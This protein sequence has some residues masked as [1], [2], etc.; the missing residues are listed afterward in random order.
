[1]SISCF[2]DLRLR[3]FPAASVAA[4]SVAAESAAAGSAAAESAAAAGQP[5][6]AA[7]E[8]YAIRAPARMFRTCS[9]RENGISGPAV[10][11]GG[12]G[13]SSS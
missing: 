9:A 10:P 6:S 7:G 4:G 3:Y 8:G 2:S 5:A 12:A 1:M 11:S 13:S